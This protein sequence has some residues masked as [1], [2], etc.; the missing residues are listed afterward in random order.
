MRCHHH[1]F[2]PCRTVT[3]GRV[4]SPTGACSQIAVRELGSRSELLFT[5]ELGE[6]P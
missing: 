4:T 6:F 1:R 5:E 2:A 3:L